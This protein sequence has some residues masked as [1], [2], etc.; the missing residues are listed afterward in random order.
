MFGRRPFQRVLRGAAF[1]ATL[2]AIGCSTP[3]PGVIHYNVD[4]CD[5]CRMTIAD[6]RFA[7]QLVTRTGKV[8]R[9][10]DPRC[11]ANFVAADRV[12][13]A[14]VHSVW[15]NDYGTPDRLVR[16]D[17]A[18]FVASDQIRAPMNGGAAAFA[19][20]S[21]AEVLKSTAGGHFESWQEFLK[22]TS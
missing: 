9:F 3:V 20:R 4:G 19:T 8:Y 16:A 21:D 13:P 10:D 22:A 18:V 7:A 1:M 5:H 12:P 2:A 6:P 15:L 14:D 17:E 11:L